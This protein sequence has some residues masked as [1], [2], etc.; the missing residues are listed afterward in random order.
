MSESPS[1]ACAACAE[2]TPHDAT[3]CIKC[4]VQLRS[5]CCGEALTTRTRTCG[6]GARIETPLVL[7]QRAGKKARASIVRPPT[8]PTRPPAKQDP[9]KAP[10]QD[11]PVP[12]LTEPLMCGTCGREHVP[13]AKHVII[14]TVY[15]S[16]G[17]NVDTYAATC[18]GCRR[19]IL[20]AENWPSFAKI[21]EQVK[22]IEKW[23]GERRTGS[24][25][26][27]ERS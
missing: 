12:K 8:S 16:K 17:P 1:Q 11:E 2:P 25:P 10:Q 18:P 24:D 4:G 9:G 3:F 22:Q 26:Q 6:C 21:T 19:L 23:H 27:S 13:R 20:W 5:R 15:F 7:A 14:T